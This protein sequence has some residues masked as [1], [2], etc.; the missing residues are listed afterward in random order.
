MAYCADGA[1]CYIILAMRSLATFK[2]LA[3]SFAA[4]GL[5]GCFSIERAP[6]LRTNEEHVLVSNYGW[7]LFHFIPVACG[8]AN[9]NRWTPWVHFRDDV[10]MDK[11]QRRFMMLAD[12]PDKEIRNPTYTTYESVMLEIPGLNLPLPVPYLLTYR[13][14][15]LSGIISKKKPEEEDPQ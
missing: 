6:L 15:Q 2:T 13:E 1:K 10:T 12:D 7:Y 4:L 14:I 8:N 11:V 3:V 9:E 5:A